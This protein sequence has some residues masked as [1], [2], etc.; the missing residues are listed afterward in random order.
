[1][2]QEIQNR[3]IYHLPEIHAH[4]LVKDSTFLG[5]GVLV[6]SLAD[7]TA[8]FQDKHRG[9]CAS[10]EMGGGGVTTRGLKTSPEVSP[11]IPEKRIT[12][13]TVRCD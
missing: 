13:G 11:K 12:Y 2:N 1:V 7:K 5:N 10:L 9:R 4:R 8:L 3:T 6:N